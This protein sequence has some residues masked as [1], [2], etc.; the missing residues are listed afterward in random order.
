M[1]YWKAPTAEELTSTPWYKPED[2]IKNEPKCEVWDENWDVINLF[3]MYS[4][5]LRMG[6]NGP[7]GLDFNV[8][9]HELDRKGITGDAYDEY[10]ANL[11]TIER[12]AIAKLQSPA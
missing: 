3:V 1:L 2:F 4:A 7:I 11:R 10:V 8:F 5:Q 12:A 6:P 9:F